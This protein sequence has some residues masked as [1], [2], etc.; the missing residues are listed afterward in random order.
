[1]SRRNAQAPA[2][3]CRE[4]VENVMLGRDCRVMLVRRGRASESCDWRASEL[5]S[6]KVI[7][8]GVLDVRLPSLG[9]SLL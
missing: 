5:S 9:C 2:L 4:L 1:M 3:D 7:P 6:R 8:S